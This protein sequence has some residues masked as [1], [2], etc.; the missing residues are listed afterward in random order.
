MPQLTHLSTETFPSSLID[1][2][3]AAPMPPLDRGTVDPT[4]RVVLEAS[5]DSMRID[6]LS[7]RNLAA[8]TAALWLLAGDLDRSHAISQNLDSPQGSFWHGVM[9]R[10]EGDFGNAKYWF[11]RAGSLPFDDALAIAVANDPVCAGLMPQ[12]NWDP[13]RFC[14]LCQQSLATGSP[15]ERQCIEAQWIEWQIAVA[16]LSIKND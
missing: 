10:R 3:I 12:S 1:P 6:G 15:L 11:R 13:M 7:K 9:H 5:D 2:I 8:A 4:L 16:S 14:D